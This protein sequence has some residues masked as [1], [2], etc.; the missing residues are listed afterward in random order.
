MGWN[1]VNIKKNSRFYFE[2]EKKT[3][4]YFAHSY[5]VECKD[6]PYEVGITNYGQNFCSIIENSN[7]FGVQFH[8]E[9]SHN[10]GKQLFRTFF[11]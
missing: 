10:F 7:I 4:F 8:P 6:R 3:K 5:Y 1:Y 9:K 11:K 2:S